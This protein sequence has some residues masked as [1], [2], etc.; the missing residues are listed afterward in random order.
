M[1][2]FSVVYLGYITFFHS[3]IIGHSDIPNTF[4]ISAVTQLGPE[5]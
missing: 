5:N 2:F 4:R 1:I 3:I